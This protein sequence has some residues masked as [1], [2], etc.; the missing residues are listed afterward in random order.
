M[1]SIFY[2]LYHQIMETGQAR[3]FRGTDGLADGEQRRDFVYVGDVVRVN[4][5][6]LKTAAR[7]E[8][9]TAARALRTATTKRRV[10]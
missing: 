5:W 2:Q 4:L 3:L 6:F 10:Q 1:A 9:T 7:A 8:S